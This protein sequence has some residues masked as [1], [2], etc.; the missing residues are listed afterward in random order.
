MDK[1]NLV[2]VLL[3]SNFM[4]LVI[5][6]KHWKDYKYNM[7]VHFLLKA[8]VKECLEKIYVHIQAVLKI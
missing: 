2:G 1:G 6:G 4:S 7:E 5:I 8:K 3:I